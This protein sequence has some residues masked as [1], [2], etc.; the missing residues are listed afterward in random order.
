METLVTDIRD[1]SI[2]RFSKLSKKNQIEN[3]MA[4]QEE[5]SEW[6]SSNLD[7]DIEIITLN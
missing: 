7:D 4:L 1:W 3:A 6:L 5:F 2:K